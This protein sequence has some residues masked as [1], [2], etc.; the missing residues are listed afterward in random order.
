MSLKRIVSGIALVMLVLAGVV[1][2]C[3][4]SA[5]EKAME[6]KVRQD[7]IDAVEKGLTP[8]PSTSSMVLTGFPRGEIY[9]VQHD[10]HKYVICIVHNGSD[11]QLIT[12][13][14]KE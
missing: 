6:E 5:E 14:E 8:V 7:S 10:G 1:S 11:F 9:T 12:D 13:K 3:G 2:G 4:P